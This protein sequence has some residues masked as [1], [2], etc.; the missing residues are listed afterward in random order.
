MSVLFHGPKAFVL[1]GT[2]KE[3]GQLDRYDAQFLAT[4]KSLRPLSEPDKKLADGLRLRI[5][6]EPRPGDSFATLAKKSPLNQYSESI[7]RLINARFPEGEPR[8]GELIRVIE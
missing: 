2:T 8:T 5:K 3:A 1:F 6:Q 7:L 4:A